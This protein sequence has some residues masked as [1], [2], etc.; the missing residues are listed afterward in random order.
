MFGHA[1]GVCDGKDCEAGEHGKLLRIDLKKAFDLLK[2][3]GYR[4]YCSIEYDA[5]G[6]SYLATARL[7]DQTI[8]YLS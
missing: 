2:S 3:D 4:G 5:S 6:D 1:Y 8:R 7:I